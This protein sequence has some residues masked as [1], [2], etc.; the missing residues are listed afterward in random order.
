MKIETRQ[1]AAFMRGPVT[2]RAVLLHGDDE[3][4]IHER[5]AALTRLVAGSLTDPFQVVELE[6][7]GWP[8]LAQE[9]TAISMMGGRR[10]VRV[11]DVT[12]AILEPLKL[13]L[14]TP[15]DALI[16]LEAPELGRGKLRTFMEAGKDLASLACYP[17]EGAALKDSIRRV[18]SEHGVSV[19]AEAASWLAETLGASRAMLVAE[20]DKLALL[21][22][23]GGRI[24]LPTARLCGGDGASAA[25]D[26]GLLAAT[27]GDLIGCDRDL[28]R[29]LAEGVNGIALIRMALFH[30]QEAPPGA[31]S[32]ASRHGR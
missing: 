11:R 3:G 18:L 14:K 19:D 2:A 17:E 5:G 21:A 31:S 25:A 22:G 13:A 15:G 10:V 8:T 29:A 28:D 26:A 23:A 1:V 32:H 9:T 6:R 12:D 20:L 7:A 4:L 24:D 16:V 27:T 30:L